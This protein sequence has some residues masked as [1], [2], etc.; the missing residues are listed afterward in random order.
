MNYPP[1][2]PS[3]SLLM[4]SKYRFLCDGA[5]GVYVKRYFSRLSSL[6]PTLLGPSKT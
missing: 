4:T 1:T 6:S 2:T 5:G 3:S